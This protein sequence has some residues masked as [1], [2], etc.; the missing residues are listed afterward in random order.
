[1]S[2]A[3]VWK[4]INKENL[5]RYNMKDKQAREE[6][7]DLRRRVTRLEDQIYAFAKMLGVYWESEKTIKGH[8]EKYVNSKPDITLQENFGFD[9]GSG[10]TS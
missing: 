10:G 6:I 7:E 9:S 4:Y 3:G 1:M 8:W 2:V 5:R